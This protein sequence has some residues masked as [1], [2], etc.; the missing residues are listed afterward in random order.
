VENSPFE[1]GEK[2]HILKPLNFWEHPGISGQTSDHEK[3][4]EDYVGFV[5]KGQRRADEKIYEEVC[6]QLMK[7]S[8]VDA[9]EMIVRVEGGVVY[10][11]GK[12]SNRRMKKK[13]EDLAEKVVGVI[14]VKNE[15]VI[16]GHTQLLKG[17]DS[18]LGKDLGIY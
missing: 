15:L 2:D 6:E 16:L 12:V 10:L 18:V 3:M 1:I 14:D 8:I 13:A 7:S 17:S 11:L 9:S 4:A 5:P